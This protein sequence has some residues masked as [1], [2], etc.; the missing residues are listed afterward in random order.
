MSLVCGRILVQSQEE[1]ANAKQ[2]MSCLWLKPKTPM[3]SGRCVN[4]WATRLASVQLFKKCSF[5]ISYY[6]Y[7]KRTCQLLWKDFILAK[8]A[9]DF[10]LRSLEHGSKIF[11]FLDS[12]RR[13]LI[14]KWQEMHWSSVTK[15]TQLSFWI[16]SSI[17]RKA[18]IYK[19]E[20]MLDARSCPSETLFMLMRFD[21]FWK[22]SASTPKKVR[23]MGFLSACTHYMT[24]FFHETS[25][26]FE[27][28]FYA[29]KLKNRDSCNII[30]CAE[31]I[32]HD[33]KIICQSFRTFKT[34]S[35][36]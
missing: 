19:Y 35:P 9:N 12:I 13:F 30:P 33:L 6:F 2:L 29:F 28:G 16:K 11:G 8:F 7:F 25:N 23:Q 36:V 24:F 14:T 15:P 18:V 3:L 32:M 1:H 22:R 17:N 26:H 34:K 4:H 31:N 27:L 20:T 10:T 21:D 5:T